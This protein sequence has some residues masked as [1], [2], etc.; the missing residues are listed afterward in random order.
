MVYEY[1]RSWYFFFF[2]N[3]KNRDY[4][5]YLTEAIVCRKRQQENLQLK[6]V[7]LSLAYLSALY[8][9]QVLAECLGGKQLRFACVFG[10]RSR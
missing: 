5:E 10:S 4:L 7:A 9:R 8:K 6:S 2:F 3:L 1:S